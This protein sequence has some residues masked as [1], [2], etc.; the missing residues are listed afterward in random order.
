MSG[1]NP[2]ETERQETSRTQQGSN[3]EAGG[4]PQVPVPPYDELRGEPGKNT[5]GRAYDASN[6]PE[7]GPSPV[8]SDEERTGVTGTELDPEPALGVGTSSGGRAEELAPDRPDTDTKGAG[9]PVGTADGEDTD[10]AG[11][12]VS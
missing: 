12:H 1:Q 4:E 6:A 10:V 3:G 11:G 2:E 9:R 8:V 7:P 5:A